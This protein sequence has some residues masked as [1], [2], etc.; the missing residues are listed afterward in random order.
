MS[1]DN[2]GEKQNRND[3]K[4]YSAHVESVLNAAGKDKETGGAMIEELRSPPGAVFFDAVGTLIHPDPPAPVVYAAVGRHYGSNLDVET[5][6]AHFR[7]AFRRQEAIDRLA[8]WH[9][10]KTG[11]T[12]VRA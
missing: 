10:T 9:P 6:T 1:R 4:R 3:E 8:A 12:L 2:G 7:A 5:I 11:N